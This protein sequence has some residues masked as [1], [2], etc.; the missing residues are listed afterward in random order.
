[1]F[2]LVTVHIPGSAADHQIPHAVPEP[3]AARLELGLRAIRRAR[4]V[5]GR[6]VLQQGLGGQDF[7]HVLGIRL[8][9]GCQVNVAAGGKL[10]RHERHQR[11]L[12]DAPLVVPFLGPRIGEEDVQPGKRRVGDHLFQHVDRVM[13][14]HAQVGEA[15]LGDSPEQ[16]AYAGQMDLDGDVVVLAMGLGDGY[17][18][19]AHAG[20]DFQD[21]GGS[22]PEY[23]ARFQ[24]LIRKGNAE[25]RKQGVPGAL[26]GVGHAPLAQDEA[27]DSPARRRLHGGPRRLWSARSR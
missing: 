11:R 15:F 3:Q 27:L 4:R 20:A 5:A 18:G 8:P 2:V 14:D 19:L 6:R 25:L 9:V 7:E 1:M 17:A 23:G 21:Q 16:A 10:A 22:A 26:L 12:D 24:Q 13:P